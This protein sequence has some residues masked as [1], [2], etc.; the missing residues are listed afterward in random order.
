MGE[1]MSIGKE[2]VLHVARLAELAVADGE[3]NRLV[4]QMNRIVDYVAQLN[5]VHGDAAIPSF[6]PGPSQVP[7]RED[8]AAPAAPRADR[9]RWWRQVSC[10]PRSVPKPADRCASRPAFA[11]SWAL[12]RATGG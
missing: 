11:A 6:L 1:R 2:E 3:L 10:P 8:V 12:S 5:Q 9:R 7:L 4:D